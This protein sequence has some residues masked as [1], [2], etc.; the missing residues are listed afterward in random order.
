MLF[1]GVNGYYYLECRIV[2]F[3]YLDTIFF[4][5]WKD[6]LIKTCNVFCP[7]PWAQYKEVRRLFNEYHIDLTCASTSNDF[8]GDKEECIAS[9]HNVKSVLN[10]AGELGIKYLRV[11]AGFTPSRLM[12]NQKWDNLVDMMN[13][14]LENGMRSG[15]LPAIELHGAVEKYKD[16]IQHIHSVTTDVKLLRNLLDKLQFPFGIVFDPANLGAVN[17]NENQIIELYNSISDKIVYFHIK[18]FR[19]TEDGALEPCACSEGILDW[20]IL[21]RTFRKS[22]CPAFYEYENTQDIDEGLIKTRDYIN[23]L[24]ETR[25]K[26]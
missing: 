5:F 23:K 20:S 6:D 24:N 14:T 26:S 22:P 12:D 10:I 19:N 2:G 21:W 13:I 25:N 7:N 11:F 18:D 9:L 8:T 15:V 17:M 1:D 3:S 4:L 16:G